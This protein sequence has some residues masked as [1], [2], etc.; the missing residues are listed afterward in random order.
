[1]SHWKRLVLMNTELVLVAIASELGEN[2]N[3]HEFPL[4][5]MGST[6]GFTRCMNFQ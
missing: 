5:D 2:D 6:A 4:P 3:A 1:M